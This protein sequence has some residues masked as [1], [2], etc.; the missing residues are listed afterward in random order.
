MFAEDMLSNPGVLIPIK[1][2][3]HY[4]PMNIPYAFEVMHSRGNTASMLHAS[5]F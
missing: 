1:I 3:K 2:Y 4:K 5:Q